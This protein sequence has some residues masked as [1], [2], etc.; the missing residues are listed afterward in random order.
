MRIL[1]GFILVAFFLSGCA[2]GPH[3]R[4][5]MDKPAVPGI[6]HEVKKGETLWYVS[7]IYKVDLKRIID[8]N[9]LPNASKIEVGQLIFV[10]EIREEA[11][12]NAA[13]PPAK[14][15]S[16]I[17]PVKGVVV[18]Y[19]GSTKDMTKNSGIDIEAPKRKN[20]L[21]SRSGKVTFASDF[22]KGYG[23]T[24]IIDHHDGFQTV[25]T[26]NAKNLVGVNEN[27]KRGSVIARVGNTGRVRK[28][29]L[30]FE[31]RKNHKPQNPFYYLP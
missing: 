6:Y 5:D 7:R 20:V 9:R 11:R 24:I 22:M 16:F 28:P 1:F 31:I 13:L 19:F 15:E 3:Y 21:A 18:S 27:V 25:Y 8:A 30:H 26:H 23:K 2:T 29:T 4:A 14:L 10:P 12:K 17:W